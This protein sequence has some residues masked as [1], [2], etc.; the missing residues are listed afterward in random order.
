MKYIP[1]FLLLLFLSACSLAER[2]ERREDRLIG[3]WQMERATFR[4]LGG[5]FFQNITD[6]FAG[7]R[8]R[9]FNNLALEYIAGNGEVF[10]GNWRITAITTEDF[11]GDRDTDFFLDAEFYDADFNLAFTWVALIER[12]DN[13]RLKVL[14]Q[15]P[16]GDLRLRWDRD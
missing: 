10:D 6:E 1:L 7:D 8:V 14:I 2:I 15:E 12:L 3:S 11:D 9:F 4:N 5:I 16:D 13:V